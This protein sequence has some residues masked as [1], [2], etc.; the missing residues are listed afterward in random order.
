MKDGARVVCVIPALNEADAIARVIAEI[1]GWVDRVIVADNGSTDETEQ[2]ARAAG[3][4]VVR[5]PEPGYGAACLAGIALA[6]DAD[7][8]VFLDGDYSDYPSDMAALVDPI[9]HGEADF[10][11]GSRT[12]GVRESG[13]LTLPQR[14]GNWLATRLIALIWGTRYT[15]LGP[16]RA[17]RKTALD[18]LEMAD[19]NYGWTVEMQIKAV[20]KGLAIAEVPVRYRNRIG[21]SKVSGTV[22]GTVLAGYKILFI[23]GREAWRRQTAAK[24]QAARRGGPGAKPAN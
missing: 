15:D 18:R 11:L 22:R 17:I 16:F 12:Q 7:I 21:V 6:Q 1:P 20:E 19:R 13:S 24:P 14:F 23:I 2:V 3:A 5:E 8:I 4:T 10:V 9:I